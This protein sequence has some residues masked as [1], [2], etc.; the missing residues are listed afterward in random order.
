M[1]RHIAQTFGFSLLAATLFACDKPG[2]TEQ[3][4]EDKANEQAAKAQNEALQNAQGAQANAQKDIT[5]AQSDFEKAREDYRHTR[6]ADLLDLDKKIADL[7]A[8][9]KTGSD[10]VK[11]DL[12]ARLPVIR[13][14]RDT[15]ARNMQA[16]D[17]TA[18]GMWDGAKS[19]LDKEWDALKAAVDKAR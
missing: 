14:Q 4:K 18:P 15:F 10:K 12:A 9:A 19:N 3:Q 6:R 5:K 7:E 11:S 17:M 13:A 16:L 1:I 8:D 2:A